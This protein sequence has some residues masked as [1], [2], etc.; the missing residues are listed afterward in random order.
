MLSQQAHEQ[1]KA[2]L[3]QATMRAVA[4]N[5]MEN[6]STRA[7]SQLCGINEVYI[8]RYFQNKEDM[9]A[10]VFDYA[11]ERF[12]RYLLQ[13]F[14]VM[15]YR[16]MEYEMRCRLLFTRCW[17]YLLENPDR[18][19]FYVRYYCSSSF[20]K[21]S[22]DTHRKRFAVLIEKMK[23]AC[24]ADVNAETVLHHLLDTL[25]DQA[26]RQITDPQD[27]AQTAEDTFW[28]LFSVLNEGRT[29]E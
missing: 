23:P 12:L 19:L 7:I 10:R 2:A 13:E 9:I 27:A 18:L 29:G 17:N 3:M 26:R 16:E 28:L 20:K 21:Y 5:G 14:P 6:T 22:Y 1:K 25:L 24:R 4:E 8:Y 11:D 15:D